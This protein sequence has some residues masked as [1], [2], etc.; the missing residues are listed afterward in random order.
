MESCRQKLTGR[1]RGNVLIKESIL[2]DLSQYKYI[3]GYGVGQYYDY[4]KS[5]IPEEVHFDFLCDARREQI[6]EIYDGIKVI[7]P[8]ELKVLKGAFVIVFSGNPRTWQSIAN[9]LDVM[10][11][12][13]VHADK[14]IHM[15]GRITG[16]ELRAVKNGVYN[17]GDGNVIDFFDDVEES[18]II[19]FLGGNNHIK[20]GR[21]VSVGKLNIYC[22][23]NVLCSIGDGTEIEEAKMIITDGKIEMGQDCLLSTSVIL[24]NHDKHHIFDKATGKRLNY[25]GNMKIG[26]HVWLCHGVTLLGSA[27]IGDNSIVGTMAVTSSSFPKEVIIA[28]NPAKVIREQVCWSK[29]NTNFYNRDFLDECMAREASKY[30]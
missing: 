30:F 15:R 24:R 21:Q 7:S 29:D 23:Q 10:G 6:G 16:K 3:I 25:A 22:G 11:L 27:A 14:V 8:E 5:K 2:L 1:F 4:I 13:Y 9:D 17:A 26:N 18:I 19:H 28:G 20:I 12:A